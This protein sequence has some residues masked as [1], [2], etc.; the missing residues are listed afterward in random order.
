M[1]NALPALCDS[2]G[3]FFSAP[4]LINSSIP[5]TITDCGTNCPRCGRMASILDGTYHHLSN[6][7]SVLY[8]T[9]V[10]ERKL[11]ALA[12][13][14]DVARKSNASP[15]EVRAAIKEHAPELKRLSDLIPQTR[16]ELYAL[17]AVILAAIAIILSQ[18]SHV[19]TEQVEAIVKREMSKPIAQPTQASGPQQVSTPN[20]AQRRA[21]R[22]K[23]KRKPPRPTRKPR[24]S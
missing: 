14:L 24:T 2:C 6:A 7:V 23:G 16:N 20:R 12:N 19:T 22:S 17:I 13:A 11:K 8:T 4:N 18:R 1:S 21:Q 3:L 10:S 15:E 9:D 5:F